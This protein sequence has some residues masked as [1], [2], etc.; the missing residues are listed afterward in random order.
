MASGTIG[1]NLKLPPNCSIYFY[2]APNLENNL[3]NFVSLPQDSSS[4]EYQ[5]LLTEVVDIGLSVHQ[6]I[7]K[8]QTLKRSQ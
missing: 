1:S 8:I 5:Q 2:I 7:R 4:D 3:I 6:E